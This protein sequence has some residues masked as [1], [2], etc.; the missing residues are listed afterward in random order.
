MMNI[1]QHSSLVINTVREQADRVILFYSCGKD[2]IAMLDMVASH[3]KEVVC[4]YMYFVK[5]LNHIDRFISYSKTKYKNITFLEVPHW[6][7]S[8]VLKIGLFCQ[9]QKNI[10][11]LKLR[12]IIERVRAKTGI[13]WCFLG[14]KQS[15]SLNRRL[16]LRTYEQ[17][18]INFD[19]KIA[20][21]LSLWKKKEVLSYI[22]FHNLPTP[23]E[24]SKEA[25]NGLWFDLKVYLWMK[26]NEPK[27]LE[28]VLRVFPLS[29]K[30]LFDYERTT[31]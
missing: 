13:D 5:N 28:K 22:K 16:M 26:E 18:A 1:Q 31:E 24:Y 11:L 6:N 21:P 12:D 20:Y 15:D 7:L 17:E 27:D 2:S 14:M 19:S 4:V 10:K 8:R 25:G 3:F 9:P 23:V 30:I 29:Q